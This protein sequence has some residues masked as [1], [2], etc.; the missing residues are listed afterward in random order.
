MASLSEPVFSHFCSFDIYSDM[1][2]DPNI[3]KMHEIYVFC[4]E[5]WKIWTSTFVDTFWLVCTCMTFSKYM[6]MQ[7]ISWWRR[8]RE[9]I[10]DHRICQIKQWFCCTLHNFCSMYVIKTSF[11]C[12]SDQF[13]SR[14]CGVSIVKLKHRNDH[15]QNQTLQISHWLHI[16][17]CQ[18][19]CHIHV[20]CILVD[21]IDTC[22]TYVINVLVQSS[23]QNIIWYSAFDPV[24]WYEWL[25][26]MYLQVWM[27][28]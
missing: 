13:G 24:F 16:W 2:S 15:S 1:F 21:I 27:D 11:S 4:R 7:E 5:V 9:D 25:V 3:L 22:D 12:N 28:L 14:K 8:H 26:W 19:Y 10:L 20:Y 17:Y 18:K 23:R 6:Q